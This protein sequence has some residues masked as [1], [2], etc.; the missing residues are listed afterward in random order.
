MHEMSIAMS[1]IDAVIEKARLE[2]CSLVTEIDLVVGQLAGVQIE[3]LKFCF[4]AAAKN[5]P[6]EG[7]ELLIEEREGSGLCEECGARFAIDSFH[8]KCPVCGLF[9]V[10]VVSGEELSVRS[11]T[12]E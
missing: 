9:R 11:I 5:T 4:S 12:I 8:T 6:A 10:R 2:G 1:V 7:A 3:S